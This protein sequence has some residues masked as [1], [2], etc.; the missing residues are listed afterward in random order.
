[1]MIQFMMHWFCSVICYLIDDNSLLL[2]NT[3]N[4]FTC[5]FHFHVFSATWGVVSVHQRNKNLLI[6][7]AWA[8]TRA[9]TSS[10]SR[11]RWKKVRP[12]D[13]KEKAQSIHHVF[14]A[15]EIVSVVQENI[16]STSFWARSQNI[17]RRPPATPQWLSRCIGHSLGNIE[18][19][20]WK[21]AAPLGL[22]TGGEAKR[23]A[24][25]FYICIHLT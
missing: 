16:R 24:C 15:P 22:E 4:E 8:T 5:S 13:E 10:N 19:G 17:C 18:T 11:L 21:P 25:Q 7:W 20:N 1:M 2:K 23:I 9:Q 6:G 3:S 14:V 12:N